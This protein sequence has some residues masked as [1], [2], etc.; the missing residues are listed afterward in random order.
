MKVSTL[1]SGTLQEVAEETKRIIDEVKPLTKFFTM[2][3][4]NNLSPCTPVE[5]I[6][7]MYDTVREYGVY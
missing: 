5:N 7:A 2:I 3:S 4:A 1:Q 6:A